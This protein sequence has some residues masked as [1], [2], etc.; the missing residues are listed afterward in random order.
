MG[1]AARALLSQFRAAA[2]RHPD[3]PRFAELTAALTEASPQFRRLVGA[4]PGAI[5]PARQDPG[6]APA[7]RPDRPRAVPAAA[8]GRPG[9]LMVTQVPADPASR[10]RV[11]A[12]G[13][14]VGRAAQRAP[15][16]RA[17]VLVVMGG[18]P[19]PARARW[20]AC[21]PARPVSRL[22]ALTG[23]SRPSSIRP[24]GQPLRQPLGP[25]GYTVAYSVAAEQLRHGVSV[26]A[27][28]V[29]PLGVDQGCLARRR[30]RLRCR[31][32]EVEL[33]C[34]TRPR[35][36]SRAGP[37]GWTSPASGCRTGSRSPARTALEPRP[38]G[39]RHR[40][41]H[42]PRRRSRPPRRDPREADDVRA[43]PD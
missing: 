29:N 15:A 28:C 13:R 35:T 40:D 14:A 8:G 17:P 43:D 3:D 9:Q 4:V 2:G 32:V 41:P 22:S 10:D 19:P 21:W 31:L 6:Q 38:P 33:V 12:L 26:I 27:E 30:G 1:P 39:H 24:P 23:S 34:T 11:A 42:C 16:A 7:S 37:R 20:P 25:V 36:A 5:L 18:C